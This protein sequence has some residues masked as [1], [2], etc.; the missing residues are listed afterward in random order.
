MREHLAGYAA[1]H[2]DARVPAHHKA[3]DGCKLGRWVSRQRERYNHPDVRG[4]R[5]LAPAQVTSLTRLG[6]IWDASTSRLRSESTI[7]HPQPRR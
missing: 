7:V 6:M 3:A 5:P 4:N 2:G 1:A